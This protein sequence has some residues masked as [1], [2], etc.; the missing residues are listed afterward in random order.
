V[1]TL[2]Q[3]LIESI[4][5]VRKTSFTLAPEA[6]TQRLRNRINKG[7][8]EADLLDTVGRVFDA[9]WRAVKLYFMIGLPGETAADVEG[10]ADLVFKALDRT[11]KRGQI[12]VSVSTFVPKA[13]TPFQWER[14]IDLE[15][16]AAKQKTLKSILRHRQIELRW[17]DHRMSLLEGLFSRGDERLGG[18]IAAAYNLGCRFDGWSDQFRY[19]LWEQAMAATSIDPLSY[20]RQRHPSEH[21]PW[22]HIDSGLTDAF[23]LEEAERAPRGTDT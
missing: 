14:Q 12:T 1:E 10:I 5:R 15:E 7:N 2:S 22:R 20:L 13:H 18:L 16:T 19:D 3:G 4:R 17:H 21:L 8:S 6:G 23:L 11:N 9:G